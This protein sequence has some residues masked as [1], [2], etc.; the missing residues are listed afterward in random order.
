[1]AYI[2][3]PCHSEEIALERLSYLTFAFRDRTLA[4]K[5]QSIIL[6]DI[7]KPLSSMTSSVLN[8]QWHYKNI[9]AIAAGIALELDMATT[10]SQY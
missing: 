5:I 1:M 6:H 3:G 10:S 8:M 4:E 9:Y 2:G 7:L